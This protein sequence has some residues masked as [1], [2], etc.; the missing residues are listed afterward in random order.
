MSDLA[1]RIIHAFPGEH[2]LSVDDPMLRRHPRDAAKDELTM[3]TDHMSALA[4]TDCGGVLLV[5]L[6]RRPGWHQAGVASVGPWRSMLVRIARSLRPRPSIEIQQGV[7]RCHDVIAVRVRPIGSL[8]R[9][10]RPGAPPLTI[11]GGELAPWYA[12]TLCPVAT[13]LDDSGRGVGASLLDI[14]PRA[15]EKIGLPH[16]V[17]WS[18]RDRHLAARWGLVSDDGV[19]L[20]RLG[21]LALARHGRTRRVVVQLRG[22]GIEVNRVDAPL[23]LLGDVLDEVLGS[24]VSGVNRSVAGLTVFVACLVAHNGRA[25]VHLEVGADRVA[26]HTSTGPRLDRGVVRLLGRATGWSEAALRRSLRESKVELRRPKVAQGIRFELE[27]GCRAPEPPTTPPRRASQPRPS[28]CGSRSS[29]S[30]PATS[31]PQVDASSVLLACLPAGASRTRREIQEDLGWSRS[32]LRSALAAAV[33][34]GDILREASSPRSPHQSYRR[35]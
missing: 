11:R 21:A 27:L 23:V 12:P 15:A 18:V 9:V 26:I 10:V 2:V 32:K 30:R 3:L 13:S 25:Q 17:R 19:M 14:D 29:G 35:A 20:T 33:A 16:P 31:S 4:N 1:E 22:R 6:P 34:R 24:V 28:A 8:R 7:D 5:G